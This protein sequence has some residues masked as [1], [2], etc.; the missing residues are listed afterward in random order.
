M[1]AEIV[2]FGAIGQGTVMKLINN[3]VM[4]TNMVAAS[5]GLVMG[6]KAGLDPDVMTDL[7]QSGTGSSWSATALKTVALP[8]TFDFG[9]KMS[10]VAKDV[11]LALREAARRLLH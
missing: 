3:M 6:A 4:A 1:T 5:E 8:G 7:L 9:A 2:H 11:A 10:I